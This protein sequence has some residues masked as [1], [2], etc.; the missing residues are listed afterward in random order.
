MEIPSDLVH[1]VDQCYAAAR[2]ELKDMIDE[3]RPLLAT[4]GP[5]STAAWYSAELRMGG[6]SED[7]L[8]GLVGLAIVEL[9]R[10]EDQSVSE[11]CACGRRESGG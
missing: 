6:W 5:A 9:A 11:R 4:D 3:V 2:D 10:R 7:A 8:A 1:E